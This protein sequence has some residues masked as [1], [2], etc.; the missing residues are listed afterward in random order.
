MMTLKKTYLVITYI[1][2]VLESKRAKGV[3]A[4]RIKWDFRWLTRDSEPLE[5]HCQAQ[6]WNS[7][8]RK[9]RHGIT[10]LVIALSTEVHEVKEETDQKATS[11]KLTLSST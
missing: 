5:V 6:E 8:R 3:Y 7:R 1:R 4:L 2:R 9:L 10:S 11:N